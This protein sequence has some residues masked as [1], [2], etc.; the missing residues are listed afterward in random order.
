MAKKSLSSKEQKAQ[1]NK[2][3][4]TYNKRLGRLYADYIR[5]LSA[6]YD[7]SDKE[8]LPS[9]PLFHFNDYPEL[10]KR[11]NDIFA[12]YYQNSIL[13]YKAG[14]TDGVALAYAHDAAALTGF[15]VL[16]NK[17]LRAARETA[18]ETFISRRLNSTKGLNL[19]QTVW[20]YCQQTKSEFEMAMANVLADGLKAGTSAETIGRKIRQY[21]NNPDMMYRRYHT[22]K[23]LKNGTKKDVVTWRRKRI[24]DGKVRFVE[25]PLEQ[26]GAGV[27]RSSRMNAL[28]VARTEINAAY[29]KARN[30]RWKNEPFVIGQWIHV[31]PEHKIDDI[32]NELEDRYPKDFDW[33]GWHP[34][35]YAEGTMVLTRAGW[36]EFKNVSLKDEILSLNPQTRTMEYTSIEQKQVYPYE[37]DMIRFYNRSLDCLVTPEHQMVYQ[38]KN[39]TA[40]IARCSALEYRVGKGGF[41]RG[42]EYSA[43]NRKEIQLG[44]KIISFD[45]YC[46]F[47]GYYLAD[48]SMMHDYGIVLS[49]KEGEPAYEKMIA[50]IHK[51]GFEPH[52]GKET[53]I[54]YHRAIGRTLLRFGTA[55]SKYVPQEILTASKRQIQIFLDAFI[56]CDGSKRAPRAFTGNHGHKFTSTNE[57][58]SYYTTSK[59]LAADLGVLL[60][61]TDKRPSYHETKPH[62]TTKKDGSII[63]SRL[64]CYCIRECRSKTATVFSKERVAYKGRVYDL[65][66]AKNHI[67]YIQ[68]NGKC[69]W[70]SNCMCTS[71]PIMIQ[72]EEKDEFYRRLYAGEDMSSFHSVFEVKDIP[73]KYKQYIQDN[74]DAIVKAAKKDKLAWHLADNKKYWVNL[75]TDEQRAEAGISLRGEPKIKTPFDI[76]KERHNARTPEQIEKIKRDWQLHRRMYYLQIYQEEMKKPSFADLPSLNQRWQGVLNS[77]KKEESAKE[78]KVALNRWKHGIDVNLQWIE[79]AK[80]LEKDGVVAT[81]ASTV[82]DW[83]L[84]KDSTKLSYAERLKNILDNVEHYYGQNNKA[85]GDSIKGFRI[86]KDEDI[87]LNTLKEWRGYINEMK[88]GDTMYVY[89]CIEHLHELRGVGS[90]VIYK[91]W[92]PFYNEAIR[93]IN[94]HDFVKGGYRKLYTQIEKAYNI[95]KLSTIP[96]AKALGLENISRYMPY[97]LLTDYIKDNPLLKGNLPTKAFWDCFDRFIP[98]VGGKDDEGYFSPKY[99]HVWIGRKDSRNISEWYSKNLLHHEFGHSFDY[100]KELQSK[101]GIKEAWNEIKNAIQKDEK[102]FIDR[103]TD[104]ISLFDKENPKPIGSIEFWDKVNSLREAGK[105]AEAEMLCDDLQKRISEH[106]AK[107]M[108]FEERLGAL[109]DVL[110]AGSKKHQF[111]APRGHGVTYFKDASMQLAEFWAHCSENYWGGN[112]LFKK[113]L[114]EY[115][116][117]MRELVEKYMV[118]N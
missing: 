51:L 79:R 97:N 45:L 10:K 55:G 83:R 35:C 56:L 4:A 91:E 102:K 101:K 20:N 17:A 108:D 18:A 42:A 77:I 112:D 67:M 78:V 98:L 21:L 114:P 95:F 69:F 15:S 63:Y 84:V 53:I 93:A 66:L 74:A 96:E 103:V 75:L 105:N 80:R 26:V 110:Q 61:Q 92:I 9:D 99:F 14:I 11:F 113:L 41:Y 70:G 31:S 13:N 106:A 100:Q 25:E 76:A 32:C 22:I 19:A 81:I 88:S 1:L 116:D 2:L 60:L 47:M 8:S 30:E 115:Y 59:Q 104:E 118:G 43:P 49:Q 34:S 57:E 65:T 52:I 37:G 107:K 82:P 39:D 46:E 85:V 94:T 109:T 12:D 3:F 71:D 58:R 38:M 6:L 89:R 64:S 86:L 40:T 111:I 33:S 5:K 117:T 90:G 16:S 48:G 44:D 54:F 62:A 28:R 23:V 7:F 73:D 36:K 24:V 29:H 68:Y 72:G 50:C 87:T 27:Y